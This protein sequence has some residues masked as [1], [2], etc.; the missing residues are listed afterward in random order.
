MQA[1][2]E[3][4]PHR[5]LSFGRS[6]IGTHAAHSSHIFMTRNTGNAIAIETLDAVMAAPQYHRKPI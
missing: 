4:G 6:H 1:R 2:E 3:S 5:R